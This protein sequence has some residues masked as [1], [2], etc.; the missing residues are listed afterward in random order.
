MLKRK[1]FF[2]M[3]LPFLFLWLFYAVMNK[4]GIIKEHLENPTEDVVSKV[5]GLTTRLETLEKKF[6]DTEN[7][8][9]AQAGQA[10]AALSSLTAISKS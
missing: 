8:M 4:A 10:N 1:T 5:S 3:I 2:G 9:S 6:S 7:R